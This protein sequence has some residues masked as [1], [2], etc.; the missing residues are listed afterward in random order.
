MCKK[1]FKTKYCSQRSG[2]SL[3][4]EGCDDLPPTVSLRAMAQ[5]GTNNVQTTLTHSLHEEELKVNE[6]DSP[7]FHKDLSMRVRSPQHLQQTQLRPLSANNRTM[8]STDMAEDESLDVNLLKM[9][10]E[11]QKELAHHATV[12]LAKHKEELKLAQHRLQEMTVK[13]EKAEDSARSRIM[14]LEIESL[15]GQSQLRALND[16]RQMQMDELAVYGTVLSRCVHC[17]VWHLTV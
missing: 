8:E 3:P 7:C 16:S 13:Q 4:A 12:S 9:D 15:R 5:K 2:A 11:K 1:R 17:L 6:E 14:E 10:L